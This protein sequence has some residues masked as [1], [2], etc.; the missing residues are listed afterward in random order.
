[1]GPDRRLLYYILSYQS[2]IL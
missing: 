1:M 2:V